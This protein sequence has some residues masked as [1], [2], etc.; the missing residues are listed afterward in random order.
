M[1][2]KNPEYMTNRELHTNFERVGVKNLNDRRRLAAEMAKRLN[3]LK[4]FSW[5]PNEEMIQKVERE[6]KHWK[7]N[8]AG[9]ETW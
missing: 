6:F 8:G 7:L 4:E 1:V 9:D 3:L 2:I 5:N